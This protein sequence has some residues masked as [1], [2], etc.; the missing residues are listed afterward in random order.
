[1]AETDSTNIALTSNNCLDEEEPPQ[2]PQLAMESNT[3][4][5]TNSEEVQ[6]ADTE[7]PQEALETS[8]DTTTT[9]RE[10]QEVVMMIRDDDDDSDPW[11]GRR[12][13]RSDS[14]LGC[15]AKPGWGRFPHPQS[16]TIPTAGDWR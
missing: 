8:M 11:I 14:R 12:T 7:S 2:S 9:D 1:M 5:A 4:S 15:A 13:A 3:K 6:Q 16:L 10:D